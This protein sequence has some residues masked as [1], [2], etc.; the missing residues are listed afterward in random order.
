MFARRQGP[1]ATLVIP[2]SNKNSLEDIQ[3]PNSL[4]RAGEDFS[5]FPLLLSLP[6]GVLN[7]LKVCVFYEGE[8]LYHA[9]KRDSELNSKGGVP[10]DKVP[11]NYS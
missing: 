3:G 1:F 8:Q 10:D 11:S 4:S 9:P 5:A 2:R 7:K 6:S